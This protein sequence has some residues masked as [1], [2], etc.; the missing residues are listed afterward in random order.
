MVCADV[1]HTARAYA[2]GAEIAGRRRY[3]RVEAAMHFYVEIEKSDGLTMARAHRTWFGRPP[4]DTADTTFEKVE[5]PGYASDEPAVFLVELAPD[6]Q[7]EGMSA[8]LKGGLVMTAEPER[9]GDPDARRAAGKGAPVRLA[10]EE[11]V[12]LL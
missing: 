10:F 2:G 11:W 7:P 9:Y 3:G 1:C 8:R 4:K 12:P 5:V 6:E